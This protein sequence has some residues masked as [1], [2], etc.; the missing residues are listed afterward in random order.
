MPGINDYDHLIRLALR[1]L[2]RIC[3]KSRAQVAEEL[4]QRLGRNVTENVLTNWASDSKL[5]YRV[6]ADVVAAFASD[7]LLRA[8]MSPEQIAAFELGMWDM[9]HLKREGKPPARPGQRRKGV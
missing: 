4:S 3:G 7:G 2:L 1:E 6:P 5:G 8:L 9:K